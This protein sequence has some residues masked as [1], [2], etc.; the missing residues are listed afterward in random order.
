MFN[1]FPVTLCFTLLITFDKFKSKFPR[2]CPRPT[3]SGSRPS[4]RSLAPHLRPRAETTASARQPAPPTVTALV[5]WTV[6]SLLHLKATNPGDQ[7]VELVLPLAEDCDLGNRAGFRR[8][9][10]PEKL[11]WKHR[12]ERVWKRGKLKAFGRTV[13]MLRWRENN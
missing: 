2:T 5:S 11:S 3:E 6:S 8:G 10:K 4:L 13:R 1:A 7:T 9:K 12:I